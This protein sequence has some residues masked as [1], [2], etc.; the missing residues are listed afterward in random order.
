MKIF[1]EKSLDLSKNR[2]QILVFC[3]KISCLYLFQ[4]SIYLYTNVNVGDCVSN[5]SE[6]RTIHPAV[7]F[8]ISSH[9]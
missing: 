9:L 1:R 5:T 6:Y 3:L 2:K 4:F 8:P 7:P